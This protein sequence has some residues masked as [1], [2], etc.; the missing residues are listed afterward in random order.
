MVIS[1]VH[2]VSAELFGGLIDPLP[3]IRLVR[4]AGRHRRQL[5]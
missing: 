2:L 1:V 5:V 4:I 3:P